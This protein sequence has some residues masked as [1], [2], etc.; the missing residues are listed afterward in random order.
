M[1]PQ[2]DEL[3]TEIVAVVWGD[4]A[5][6][7]GVEAH[8][9]RLEAIGWHLLA[10]VQR[11]W[12]GERDAGA[13]K[14]GLDEP[15]AHFI[16]DLLATLGVIE[17][18]REGAAPGTPLDIALPS[19]PAAAQQAVLLSLPIGVRLAVMEGNPQALQSA[20]AALPP[21]QA[22]Y[23]LEQL[24][25]TGLLDA[26]GQASDVQVMDDLE[27][28]LHAI[29]AAAR[30]ASMP[31]RQAEDFLAYLEGQGLHFGEAIRQLWEG[32][33]DATI[34]CQGLGGREAVIVQGI[35]DL[36]ED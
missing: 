8:L 27:P 3:L 34:L 2:L 16:D 6:R 25:E 5:R 31:R 21:E 10:P 9:Q 15:E 36:I 7:P 17:P 35:L 22:E 32:E 14:S 28:M 1:L 4:A 19:D 12:A 33:R 29:A 24:N 18:Y 30:D 23:F 26:A 20:L 13:L 11:I